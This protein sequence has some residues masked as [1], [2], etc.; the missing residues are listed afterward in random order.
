[1][2]YVGG[3]RKKQKH[4]SKA[5]GK[6]SSPRT[7]KATKSFPIVGIGASAGGLDALEKLLSATPPHP[8]ASFV[9]L[10]HQSP[11]HV[12][13]LPGILSKKTSLPIT[14]AVDGLKL[15][16]NQCYLVPPGAHM[17]LYKGALHD[18]TPKGKTID[19]LPI[20]NFFRSLAEEK[21][22][23]CACIILS[24]MGSDGTIGMRAIKEAGGLTIVQDPKTAAFPAMPTSALAT[25]LVDIIA[26][27]ED[28]TQQLITYF[29]NPALKAQSNQDHRV[30]LPLESLHKILYLL[31]AQSGHDFSNYKTNTMC[32]RI[33]RRMSMHQI[34]NPNEYIKLLKDNPHELDLL[35]RELLIR[36][37]GFFRDEDA[38]ASLATGPLT[39]LLKANKENQKIRVWVPGCATGEEP[40]SLAILFH[41]LITKL[42]LELEVQIFATDLDSSA[43]D[44]ARTGRFPIGINSEVSQERLKN[45]FV[46]KDGS[47]TVRKEIREMVVFATHNVIKDPPFTKL[48]LIC[49]RNLLIYLDSE[50]Q[51]RLFPLFHYALNQQ[52]LLFL[53]A[54]ESTGNFKDLF[55]TLDKKWKIYR[56]TGFI[57]GRHTVPDMPSELR[58]E[59]RHATSKRALS[60]FS[61]SAHI[62]TAVEKSLLAR[63]APASVVIND[64]GDILY[65]HG[66]TGMY[67]EPATGQARMN[68]IEMARE[69]LKPH[70]RSLI[71]AAQHTDE[72]QLRE[73]IKVKTNEHY[74]YVDVGVSQIHEPET[75]KG[76]LLVTFRH[77]QPTEEKI[78]KRKAAPKKGSKNARHGGDLDE[79]ERELRYTKESLQATV[80]ELESSNEELKS[81]NEELQS[82]N[83][84]LQ[85]SN[86]ELET[87][88]EEM[89]S[90]NEELNTVNTELQSKLE[91]VSE[92]N[93]D[94][95]NLLN[96]TDIATIF[97]DNELKIK[98]Y[99]DKASKLVTLR[100]T[101]IGRPIGELALNLDYATLVAD[102]QDVLKTLVRKELELCSKDGSWYLM[103]IMP[104]RTI[105]NVIQGLVITVVDI[106]RIKQAEEDGKKSRI[107][108]AELIDVV[109]QPLLLLDATLCIIAANRSFLD[110]FKM[111]SKD[112]EGASL[113]AIGEHAL[114]IPE[115]RKALAEVVSKKKQLK[116]FKVTQAFPKIGNH[117]FVLQ[118]RILDH[119]HT[120][121]G[122]V[123]LTLEDVTGSSKK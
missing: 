28:I 72:E 94:M 98:R 25:G 31:R 45:Y 41:E 96:S 15:K 29:Q 27:P 100:K 59:G 53:G 108:V 117:T 123:V 112:L 14:E 83:E 75:M 42:K 86:E 22:E 3:V 65:I 12:S 52:G 18:S 81:T 80:K 89:Q 92:V 97:L 54:S 51:K 48:D 13:L 110:S 5:A 118:A 64:R 67:L 87:S 109:N 70:L 104:Y 32:R 56:R 36:V 90:L 50:L 21:K 91:Q 34:S 58:P 105:E 84:E 107:N 95:Q 60:L 55:D 57:R 115:L 102:A 121:S 26:P 61:S 103:R 47:Y 71:R 4:T 106:S 37:T 7:S 113:Y 6:K 40:Y 1:M 10:M 2:W 19:Y 30:A 43:I 24:G 114:N 66:R 116:G 79:L 111:R 38:F 11:G 73:K 33:E 101:D 44:T 120:T 88:K 85:S 62:S 99:T 76:L 20:D 35:F 17:I 16:P 78:S 122:S 68:A 74:T 69:G 8:S 49:C 63:F 119:D 46:F 82:A 77:V 93:N 9:I 39:T 23:H